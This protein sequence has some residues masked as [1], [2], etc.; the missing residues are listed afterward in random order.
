M[1]LTERPFSGWLGVTLMALSFG[2]YVA[3]AV[4]PFLPMSGWQK[5]QV[6]LELSAVSWVMFL[7]GS[8]LVGKEGVASF[9]QRFFARRKR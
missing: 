3:Y 5:G 6:G 7:L 4:V 8:V 2:I 9:R 1:Q